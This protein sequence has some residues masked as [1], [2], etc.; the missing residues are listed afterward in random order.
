[1]KLSKLTWLILGIGIFAIAFGSLY[2]VYSRRVS[3]QEEISV[4]LAKAQDTLPKLVSQREELESAVAEAKAGLDAAKASFPDSVESVDVDE[5]L[6][7]LADEHELEITSITSPAPKDK[8][9][10]GIA[11]S[12]TSFEVIVEGDVVDILDFID[13]ITLGRDFTTATV[14]QVDMEVPEPPAEEEEK[15]SATISLIIYSYKG[16]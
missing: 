14:A 2:M 7:E 8:E 4:A 16:E 5:R 10:E 12:V 3:E 9:V 13:A 6:F 11:Y 1:M 15:P